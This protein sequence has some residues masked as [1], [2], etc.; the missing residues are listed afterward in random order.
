MGY[1][2]W[3][4]KQSHVFML[5]QGVL[6]PDH[7]TN[8]I[9]NQQKSSYIFFF[10]P[11]PLSPQMKTKSVWLSSRMSHKETKV[12]TSVTHPDKITQTNQGRNTTQWDTNTLRYYHCIKFHQRPY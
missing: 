4:K 1:L 11:R 8:E 12:L 2:K 3:G 9:L 10:P 7:S 6:R 5:H